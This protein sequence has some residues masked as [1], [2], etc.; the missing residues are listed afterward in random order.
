M[1]LLWEQTGPQVLSP[2]FGGTHLPTISLAASVPLCRL[3]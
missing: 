3:L 2:W 1:P